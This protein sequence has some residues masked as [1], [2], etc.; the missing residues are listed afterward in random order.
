MKPL[1]PLRARA[2]E[3]LRAGR[4]GEREIGQL[5]R[6]LA[7]LHEGEAVDPDADRHAGPEAMAAH[8]H[9][10]REEARR[11]QREHA[12]LAAALREVADLQERFAAAHP[13]WIRARIDARR[14]RIGAGDCELERASIED[15]GRVRFAREDRPSPRGRDGCVPVAG[16]AVDLASRGHP[17]LAERL[18]AAYAGESDDYALYRVVDFHERDRAC[19]RAVERLR[20]AQAT[21]DAQRLLAF[22]R[23]TARRPLLPRTVIALGGL[24]ACGKSTVAAAI[25]SRMGAPRIVG[26]HVRAFRM[27]ATPSHAPSAAERIGGFAPGFDE[28]VAQALFAQAECV[29][30]GGRAV[31][32]DAGFPTAAR[33]AAVRALARRHGVPFRFVECRVDAETARRRLAERDAAPDEHGGWR[34]I[35]DAYL[36]RWEPPAGDVALEEHVVLDTTRPL[37]ESVAAIEA[38]L[39][40]WPEGAGA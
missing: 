23:A 19:A 12:E 2:D 35:Y 9:A 24:V 28:R 11:V 39:P 27:G 34:A 14:I 18:L 16:L 3:R 15:D 36:T 30:D 31:V 26:D 25:A 6:R 7:V 1:E 10:L 21:A 22:A 13:D 8:A 20:A 38:Q 37:A 29:L 32:L 5:A 40:L 4:L 33:R 17:E